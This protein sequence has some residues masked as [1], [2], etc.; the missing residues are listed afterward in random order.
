MG[1]L[2]GDQLGRLQQQI[3]NSHVD[4]FT[5]WLCINNTDSSQRCASFVKDHQAPDSAKLHNCLIEWF[6]CVFQLCV[7][8][9]PGTNPQII[10]WPCNFENRAPGTLTGVRGSP[11]H[12]GQ[13][14][15][16]KS[17]LYVTLSRNINEYS[18]PQTAFSLVFQALKAKITFS[19]WAFQ[20]AV[21]TTFK[22]SQQTILWYSFSFVRNKSSNWN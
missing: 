7:P 9:T 11:V 15:H 3:K 2:N 17:W 1:M 16:P 21:A 8:G 5:S 4:G 14:P 6:S 19:T 22:A 20:I 10:V 12:C 18:L 13:A